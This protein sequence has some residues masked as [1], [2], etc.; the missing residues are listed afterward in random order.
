MIKFSMFGLAV[1]Y[2]ILN[3]GSTQ[4]SKE[5]TTSST[6]S[7]CSSAVLSMFSFVI[8]FLVGTPLFFVIEVLPNK[9]LQ[10]ISPIGMIISG[11]YFIKRLSNRS[12]GSLRC[13][14]VG[15]LYLIGFPVLGL[16][17]CTSGI[18]SYT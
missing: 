11:L 10:P 17:F 14:N 15:V 4:V 13:L 1:Q 16:T 6:S 5:S 2:S 9:F 3:I 7:P 8:V 12:S 18:M